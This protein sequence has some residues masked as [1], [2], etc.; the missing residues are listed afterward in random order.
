MNKHPK[1]LMVA[2][3]YILKGSIELMSV[4]Q[5]GKLKSMGFYPFCCAYFR[6]ID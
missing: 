2:I 4:S 5:S 3:L 6:L 1:A